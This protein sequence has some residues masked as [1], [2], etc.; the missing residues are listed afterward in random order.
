MWAAPAKELE[1][2]C[3]V[4]LKESLWAYE[5]LFFPPPTSVKQ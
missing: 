3:G 2:L 1:N 5:S 4:A